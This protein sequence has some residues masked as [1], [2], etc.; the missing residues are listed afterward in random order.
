M[1]AGIGMVFLMCR[2]CVIVATETIDYDEETVRV[3]RGVARDR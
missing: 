2:M 1:N 3:T